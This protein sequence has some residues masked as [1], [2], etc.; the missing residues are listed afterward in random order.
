MESS[1]LGVGVTLSEGAHS[2]FHFRFCSGN[3]PLRVSPGQ[4]GPPGKKG[5]SERGPVHHMA[6][7]RPGD[8]WHTATEDQL[9][10]KQEH[11][12]VAEATPK[13]G[14]SGE[15]T[16]TWGCIPAHSCGWPQRFWALQQGHTESVTLLYKHLRSPA[17]HLYF[18]KHVLRR[19]T[20]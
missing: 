11:K 18:M 15:G 20:G 7:T 19:C 2:P 13:M 5:R 6:S 10:S 12:L 8:S 9:R 4:T 16:D 3:S 17:E 1:G 14:P